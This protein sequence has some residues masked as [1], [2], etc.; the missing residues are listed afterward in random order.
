MNEFLEKK[1]KY[2]KQELSRAKETVKLWEEMLKRYER[3]KEKDN[4]I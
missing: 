3:I 1:I 2:A 4:E